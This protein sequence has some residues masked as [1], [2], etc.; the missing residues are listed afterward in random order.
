MQ[1]TYK[2][3]PYIILHESKY[4]DKGVWKEVIIYMCLYPNPDGDIWVREKEEFFKLFKRV[5]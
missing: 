5:E 1:Y 4:K 3:K 2:D